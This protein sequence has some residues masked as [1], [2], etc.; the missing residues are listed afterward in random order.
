[1]AE[2]PSRRPLRSPRPRQRLAPTQPTRMASTARDGY[3]PRR[4]R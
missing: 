2:L 1:M 4:S 3:D